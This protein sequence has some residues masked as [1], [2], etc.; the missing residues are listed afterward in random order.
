M[1][2]L[3][4]ISNRAAGPGTPDRTV[5]PKGLGHPQSPPAIRRNAVDTEEQERLRPPE[6]TGEE[7]LPRMEDRET[8]EENQL[9]A[10]RRQETEEEEP[11]ASLHR[12]SE[13]EEEQKSVQAVRRQEEEEEA[14]AQTLRRTEAEKED[15]PIQTIPRQAEEKDEQTPLQTL[16]RQE[17]EEEETS[18]VRPVRSISREEEVPLED[19]G[20]TVP[21]P[22]QENLN[23]D[24][25]PV[26]QELAGEQ[27]PSGLQ[28]LHRDLPLKSAPPRPP[29]APAPNDR[30]A[31]RPIPGTAAPD[32]SFLSQQL[33]GIETPL[34]AQQ[35][36]GAESRRPQVIIDQVDVLIQ[37]PTSSADRGTSLRSRDRAMR[38]RY[39]RR[40]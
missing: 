6:N 3:A 31:D 26:S 37:E 23:P 28:A 25:G 19:T 12:Q 24:A 18:S 2:F 30:L 8:E 15:E 11:M 13:E 10:V 36:H 20:Q 27:E 33:N 39:L 16:R 4:R 14:A 29:A 38:A 17:V 5:M 9:A 1:S 21:P 40:L 34:A 35:P 22:T 7:Q 32:S